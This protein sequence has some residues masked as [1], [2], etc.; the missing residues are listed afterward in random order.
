MASKRNRYGKRISL[1][2]RIEK[3][4]KRKCFTQGQRD[5]FWQ[6]YS[7][8]GAGKR[9]T[10]DD[11]KFLNSLLRTKRAWKAPQRSSNTR[12]RTPRTYNDN[13]GRINHMVVR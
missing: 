6:I 2:T 11:F 12:R 8:A 13:T 9:L 5:R 1:I 10:G 3:V 7:S 4:I